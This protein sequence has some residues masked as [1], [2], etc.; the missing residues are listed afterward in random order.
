MPTKVAK[1]KVKHKGFTTFNSLCST[2][3][4]PSPLA[5]TPLPAASRIVNYIKNSQMAID[6]TFI[7]TIFTK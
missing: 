4:T 3:D 6:Y 5:I 7:F 2:H 1:G